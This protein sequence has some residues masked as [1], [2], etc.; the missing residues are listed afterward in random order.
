M[1]LPSDE[2]SVVV[3]KEY[4]PP[5]V[6]VDVNLPL[7]LLALVLIFPT[8]IEFKFLHSSSVSTVWVPLSSVTVT[9]E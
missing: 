5:V 2:Y 4:I 1:R 8:T 9:C 3:T 6:T 7:V